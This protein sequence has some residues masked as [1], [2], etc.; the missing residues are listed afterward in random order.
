MRCHALARAVKDRRFLPGR[1]WMLDAN[2]RHLYHSLVGW[3]VTGFDLSRALGKARA[4]TAAA[5]S[6]ASAAG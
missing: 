1:P 5:G 6:G 3:D 4:K 2:R